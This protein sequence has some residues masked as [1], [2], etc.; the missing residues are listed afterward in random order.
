VRAGEGLCLHLRGG[1]VFTV[2]V[3]GATTAAG[4]L[5]DTLSGLDRLDIG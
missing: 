1:G 4:V 5:N 3:D 2:T